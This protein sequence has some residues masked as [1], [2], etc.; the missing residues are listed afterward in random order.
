MSTPPRLDDPERLQ[1][2]FRENPYPTTHDRGSPWHPDYSREPGPW[3]PRD[4]GAPQSI[5]T[6]G[7]SPAGI[8]SILA[9]L[10]RRRA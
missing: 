9:E 6:S 1:R 8:A 4:D 3:M 5:D 2:W 10:H 7:I